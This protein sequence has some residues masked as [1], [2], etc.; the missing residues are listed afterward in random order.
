MFPV[1]IGDLY[2][3]L[4]SD[5][6]T[7]AVLVDVYRWD[8][9]RDRLVLEIIQGRPAA[10]AAPLTVTPG[11]GSGG[12]RLSAAE[13]SETVVGYLSGGDDP[14][15]LVLRP[16][17]IVLM[18]GDSASMELTA[19]SVAGY[20]IGLRVMEH[21][22]ALGSQLPSGFPS[23][24]LVEHATVSLPDLGQHVVNTDLDH[25][26]VVGPT[27]LFPAGCKFSS[28]G[29]GPASPNLVIEMPRPAAPIVGAIVLEDAEVS[30]CTF[31]NVALVA[32]PD[33]RERM[34]RSLGIE[35]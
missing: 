35:P 15:Y 1:A 13:G 10:G 27:L 3:H 4:G 23:R 9:A 17:S 19:A 14:R 32:P 8:H 12:V 30:N 31:V 2:I 28:C 7:G 24:R 18:E 22:F 25:C 16:D 34:L 11:G 21:G 33:S 20:P 6:R 29:F 26:T 5:V